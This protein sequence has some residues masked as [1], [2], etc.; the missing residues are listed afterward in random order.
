[1]TN[2]EPSRV[3]GY[4]VP[5]SGTGQMFKMPTPTLILPLPL[6]GGGNRR[7]RDIRFEHLV[8]RKFEFAP[9]QSSLRSDA[10]GRVFSELKFRLDILAP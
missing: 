8:I 1:M 7:G 10:T 3:L 6:G 2:P 5:F 4:P 9:K